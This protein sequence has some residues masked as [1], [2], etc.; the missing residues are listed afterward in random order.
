MFAF[1]L[2]FTT[3]FVR[4]Q[5]NYY[6]D[7]PQRFTGGLVAG[8]NLAQVDGDMY[9]GYT[10]MGFSGG[11]FVKMGL[12]SRLLLSTE[13]LFSQKGSKGN[14]VLGTP[15]TGTSTAICYIGLSY[16]E[17]PVTLQYK[18]PMFTLE[19]GASWSYLVRTREWIE[20]QPSV[21]IN[22]ENNRFEKMGLD[23]VFGASRKLSKHVVASLRYQYSMIPIR[24]TARV[25]FGYSYGT[26]GQFNNLFGFRLQYEW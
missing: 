10:K 7:D 25:P 23:Y 17:A 3:G 2:S 24:P 12:A 8:V 21:V 19:A 18:F 9:F 5:E 22:E 20:A 14:A 11:A 6:L 13:L 4:A 16:V 15:L 26:K 1:F